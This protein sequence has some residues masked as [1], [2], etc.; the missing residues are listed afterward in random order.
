ME[1]EPC[2]YEPLWYRLANPSKGKKCE[3][4]NLEKSRAGKSSEK[5]VKSREM[6]QISFGGNFQQGLWVLEVTYHLK[7]AAVNITINFTI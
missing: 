2:V 7:A 4:L 6:S 3:I 5:W 1:L